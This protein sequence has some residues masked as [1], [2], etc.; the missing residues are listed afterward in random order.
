MIFKKGKEKDN[1]NTK[2]IETYKGQNVVEGHDRLCPY[3]ARQIKGDF[4][5]VT[6]QYL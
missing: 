3:E 1:R 6:L 2:F 4:L 5:D